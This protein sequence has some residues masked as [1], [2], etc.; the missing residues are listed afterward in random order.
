[1]AT[2]TAS[3]EIPALRATTMCEAFQITAAERA[4]GVA[5]RTP[6][7]GTEITFGELA[8]RVRRVAVGLAG[9]GRRAR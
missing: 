1:M 6:G 7:G 2:T 8:E 3:A 5:L 9:L 4:D